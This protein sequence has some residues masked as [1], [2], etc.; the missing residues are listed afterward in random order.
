MPRRDA[1]VARTEYLL[2]PSDYLSALRRRYWVLVLAAVAAVVVTILV[3]PSDAARAQSRQH[4]V[5]EHIISLP[6][7]AAGGDAD[8][9]TARNT[10]L[11]AA[12]RLFHS[13]EVA[14]RVAEELER[15][16]PTTLAKRVEIK[17]NKK[18]G[19]ITFSASSRKK[20]ELA[21]VVDTFADKAVDYDLELATEA[22]QRDVDEAAAQLDSLTGQLNEIDTQLSADQGGGNASLKARREALVAELTATVR[23]QT[24]LEIKGPPESRF[25]TVSEAKP[26]AVGTAGDSGG[27]K[28]PEGRRGRLVLAVALAMVLGGAVVLVLD[29]FDSRL[30]TKQ[31]A[32][33]AFGLPVLTEV[34]VTP[35]RRRRQWAVE[36]ASNPLSRVAEAYRKLRSAIVLAQAVPRLRPVRAGASGADG[37]QSPAPPKPERMA[38]EH[39][40][41]LRFEPLV[42][43]KDLK[44]ILVTSP[45]P[46]EGRSTTAVNLAASFA[47]AGR[48]VLVVDADLRRPNLD[49][50]FG[51]DPARGLSDVVADRRPAS[52]LGEA[53]QPTGHRLIR[54]VSS[55]TPADN[56]AGIITGARELLLRTRAVTDVIIV[57]TPP[58]LLYNDAAE[59]VPAADAVVVV[60]RAGRTTADD[61]ERMGELLARLGAPVFGVALLG[62]RGRRGVA[63]PLRRR[64]RR[65]AA[66]PPPDVVDEAFPEAP[67]DAPA[68]AGALL[69]DHPPE[70]VAE[71]ALADEKGPPPETGSSDRR[72]WQQPSF[73][74][75]WQPHSG[76]RRSP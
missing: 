50:Y 67:V 54:L 21:A 13:P 57:D 17:V 51:V 35:R 37:D 49:D 36:T 8:A 28:P 3:T 6:P 29:R 72:P 75:R 53:A 24:D 5:A 44:L 58:A 62:V 66:P 61:A 25:V 14:R 68:G 47:E 12:S 48:S 23:R 18:L 46:S 70:T 42:D 69:A 56:P 9:L 27:F 34:P 20:G 63:P 4:F 39:A 45:R 43:A 76:I 30:H 26:V 64:R 73:W 38:G 71:S 7:T 31:A 19:T 52:V 40:Y 2:Q 65:K 1:Q 11:A 60:A 22:Y 10:L 32:E 15:P 74:R 59:L 16:D 33:Q 55:G 41:E